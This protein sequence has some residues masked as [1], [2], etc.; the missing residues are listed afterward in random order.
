MGD[1]GDF[2]LSDSPAHS[3]K[4]WGA[5]LPRVA[6]WAQFT[7]VVND[8][9][10]KQRAFVVLNAHLDHAS[11]TARVESARLLRTKAHELSQNAQCNMQSGQGSE[12][13]KHGRSS[14]S[15]DSSDSSS[16]CSTSVVFVMGDFNAVKDEGG[17]QGWYAQLTADTSRN[18]DSTIAPP[19]V[20][21]WVH[22]SERNCGAC[23]Q[24]LIQARV[25]FTLF[26]PWSIC[27]FILDVHETSGFFQ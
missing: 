8:M 2:W 14:D 10:L 22:A 7:V 21:A 13:S 24:V 25:E 4:A 11:E 23:S 5:S 1:A 9:P 18:S 12:D 19:L 26:F 17:K 16:S 3:S 6:T 15:S 27:P 20:D